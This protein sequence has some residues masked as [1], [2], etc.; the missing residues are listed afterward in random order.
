MAKTAKTARCRLVPQAAILATTGSKRKAATPAMAKG[1]R[2]GWRKLITVESS[3]ISPT[4]IAPM[5]T[6]EKVA[7]APHMVFRC[8]RVG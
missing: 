4:A 6:T 5:V 1:M 8:Q 2:I 3:Q 7:R